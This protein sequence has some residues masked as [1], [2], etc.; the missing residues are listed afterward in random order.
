MKFFFLNIL[1]AL[2]ALN[3][4]AGVPLD[5]EVNW[6]YES[7]SLKVILEEIAVL[8]ENVDEF[9]ELYGKFLKNEAA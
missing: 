3:L 4:A 9:L 2:M 6:D 1:W 7:I 5:D 8:F